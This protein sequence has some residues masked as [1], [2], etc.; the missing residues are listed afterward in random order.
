MVKYYEMVT[1]P[2]I[3]GAGKETS[4]Q[5]ILKDLMVLLIGPP[6]SVCYIKETKFGALCTCSVPQY[7]KLHSI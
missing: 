3:R 2:I 4:P 7:M 1:M 5:Q 6:K